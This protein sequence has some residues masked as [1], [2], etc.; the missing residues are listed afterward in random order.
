MGT[1]TILVVVV[2][3]PP[4]LNVAPIVVDDTVNVSLVVTHVNVTGVEIVALGVGVLCI[5]VVLAE[6]VQALAGS[7]TV[8]V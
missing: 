3:P 1:V 6:V 5:T 7:V 8:T 4:Q 2:F